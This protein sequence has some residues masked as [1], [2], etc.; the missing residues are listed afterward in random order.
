[1]VHVVLITRAPLLVNIHISKVEAEVVI[2][3]LFDADEDAVLVHRIVHHFFSEIQQNFISNHQGWKFGSFKEWKVET[4]QV[5]H[6]VN[7]PG[8]TGTYIVFDLLYPPLFIPEPLC[9][10]RFTGTGA[11]QEL[12]V[13]PVFIGPG[14]P[15]RLCRR[16]PCMGIARRCRHS[17]L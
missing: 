2:Q 4:E 15:A 8:F 14:L 13:D 1:M 11:E 3:V 10:Q 5:T 6:S 9:D 16:E 17:F 12:L 7:E